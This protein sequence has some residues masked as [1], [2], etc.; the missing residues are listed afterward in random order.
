MPTY[1]LHCP[2]CGHRFDR[3]LVRLLRDD[4]KVC[5]ECGS[6]KVKAGVGG[7][8]VARVSE[9]GSSCAPKGGFG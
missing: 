4:D 9:S 5:P 8:F 1:E 2:E 6:T 7:G 3:F